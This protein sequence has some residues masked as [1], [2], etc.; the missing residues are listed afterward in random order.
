[1]KR[2]ACKFLKPALLW[3]AI[4]FFILASCTVVYFDQPQPVDARNLKKVPKAIQGKWIKTTETDTSTI[5]FGKTTYRFS[6]VNHESVA[7]SHVESWKKYKMKDGLIYNMFEDSTRGFP[8]RQSGDTVYFR[9]HFENVIT[10][11]DSALLRKGKGSYLLN[12]R[13]ALGWEVFLIR[14]SDDGS[15]LADYLLAEDLF[16]L[17]HRYPVSVLDSTREDTILFRARLRSGDIPALINI[18]GKGTLWKLGKDG[19]FTDD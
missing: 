9:E 6:E 13:T 10:L 3:N 14:R 12:V 1:M 2:S 16:N 17:E 8:Y 19:R 5:E 7:L 4:L 11:S 18:E 15:L